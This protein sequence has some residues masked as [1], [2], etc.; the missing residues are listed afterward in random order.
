MNSTQCCSAWSKNIRQCCHPVLSR[1]FGNSRNSQFPIIFL[2]SY[3]RNGLQKSTEKISNNGKP[4]VY[5]T[6]KIVY[7]LIPGPWWAVFQ[8]HVLYN[9]IPKFLLL[10]WNEKGKKRNWSVCK[11]VEETADFIFTH[12]TVWPMREMFSK[13]VYSKE[14]VGDKHK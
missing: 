7:Q 1:N 8:Y 2:E 6:H 4:I 9:P 10:L 5:Y 12:T 11:A 14:R 3:E 13:P